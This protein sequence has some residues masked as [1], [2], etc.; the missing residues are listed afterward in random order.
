MRTVGAVV[1]TAFLIGGVALGQD[2][3][4][5]ATDEWSRSD[6]PLAAMLLVTADPDGF[7]AQWRRKPAEGFEPE[8]ATASRATRGGTVTALVVFGGCA[9]DAYGNCRARVDY[10]V[11]RPDGSVYAE[12]ADGELW[13]GKTPPP[14]LQVAPASLEV[15][16]EPLDPL[17][18]YR[19]EAVVRDPVAGR[20]LRLA[21]A[22]EVVAAE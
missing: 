2:A 15:E 19:F 6:G 12:F 4:A 20:E 3:P 16:F 5:P 8:I 7:F 18:A 21:R 17:G 9:P 1:A 10:R 13:L 14:A 11:L 22:L